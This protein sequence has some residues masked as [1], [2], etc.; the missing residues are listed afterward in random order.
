MKI[1]AVWEQIPYQLSKEN[2]KFVFVAIA[3]SARAREYET[4]IQW[5]IG[6]G[7]SK[8]KKS[9][10]EYGNQYMNDEY[11]TKILSRSTLR[12]FIHNSDIVN[13]PLYAIALFPRL[14]P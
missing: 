12:N 10:I 6:A 4:A 5:L 14:S 3:K 7:I 9:L 13:Y 8:Q 2:K 1:T 11:R